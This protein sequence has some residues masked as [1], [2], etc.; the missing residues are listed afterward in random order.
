MKR[1]FRIILI[2]IIILIS[3]MS[4]QAATSNTTAIR[5][6]SHLLERLDSLI[7]NH[8]GII[9]RKEARI[10]LLRNE[11]KQAKS[12][13]KKLRLCLDLYK[14][15]NVYNPDSALSYAKEATLLAQKINPEDY[16]GITLC[17]LNEIFIY[18]TQ[19]FGE[20][21][22]KSF[23]KIDS[24]QLSEETR[25]EYFQ[26]GQYI[27]STQALFNTNGNRSD[28]YGIKANAYRD[29]LARLDPH[30]IHDFLWAPIAIQ[31]FKDSADYQVSEKEVELLK[32]V[33]DTSTESSR[34]NAINAYWLAHHYKMTGDEVNWVKYLTM[35]AIYDTEIENREIAAMTELAVWLFDNNEVDRAY[36]YLMYSSDQANAYHNRAR[37]LNVS[38]LLP[39][40]RDAYYEAIHKSERKLR[41]YLWTL[42]VVSLVLIGSAIYII[43]ENRRLRHTRL[44]LSESNERLKESIAARDE[45]IIALENS[46]HAL[47]NSNK[48]LSEANS[49]L[50]EAEKVKESLI[51]MSYRLVSDHINALDDYRRKLLRKFKNKQMTE[52]GAELSDN[53]LIK[54]PVKGFYSAFDHTVLSLYPDF[55]SD[56]N[57]TVAEDQQIDPEPL[58]RSRSLN[59]RLRISALNRLGI[60]K[61]ADIAR[62]LNISIRTVYNNR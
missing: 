40:I 46:N 57:K 62:I 15:Y 1:G 28:P 14:Q 56:Y 54:D 8:D 38:A 24:H 39:T 13:E 3:V 37:V 49:E 10:N 41:T 52:L 20:E 16:N 48:A 33:V 4:V 6:N 36:T 61:S 5:E 2:F 53:E 42:I 50:C 44:A 47:E 32:R 55:I 21:A 43:I 12:P 11:Y 26:I 34:E 23:E 19:G 9:S 27:Y 29:S 59:T 17:K 60:E 18:A 35:A 30:H 25:L 51:A 58:L 45:A 31:V 22:I 7:K